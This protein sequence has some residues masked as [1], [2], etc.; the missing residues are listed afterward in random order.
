MY[1][2]SDDVVELTETNFDRLVS[3]S[4][5]IWI[6]EFYAPWC[7]HCQSLTP[8][9]KKLATALKGII[10]VGAVNADEQKSLGGQFGVRGFPTIKIFG[11]NK[12]SPTDFNGERTAKGMGEAALAEA[13]KQIKSI[14]DGGSS[15]GGGNKNSNGNVSLTWFQKFENN[16]IINLIIL[17]CY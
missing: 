4:D 14:L 9:Y 15:S 3:Q 11:Q 1:S 2:P 13:R 5:N 10:K 17:G 6:V 16:F 12:K 7:G 8:E